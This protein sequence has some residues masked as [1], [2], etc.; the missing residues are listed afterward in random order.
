VGSKAKGIKQ[1][2]LGRIRVSLLARVSTAAAA[3]AA[4]F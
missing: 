1:N 4:V 2:Q 3:A